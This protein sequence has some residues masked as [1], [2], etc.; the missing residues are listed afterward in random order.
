VW[1]QMAREMAAAMKRLGVTQVALARSTGTSRRH[2]CRV[3]SAR[4][5]PSWG[6]LD[7]LSAELGLSWHVT[8]QVGGGVVPSPPEPARPANETV[9]AAGGAAVASAAAGTGPPSPG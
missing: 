8:A 7:R 3:L 5:T 1:R 9:T 6:L 4:A 2:M